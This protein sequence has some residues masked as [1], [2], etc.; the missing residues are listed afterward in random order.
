VLH[1]DHRNHHRVVAQPD[2]REIG[3]GTETLSRARQ[4]TTRSQ[5][6]RLFAR[7][8]VGIEARAHRVETP[9]DLGVTAQ[10]SRDDDREQHEHDGLDSDERGHRA[11]SGRVARLSAGSASSTW[12]ASHAQHAVAARKAR[13]TATLAPADPFSS[14]IDGGF[15]NNFNGF[16]NL[17]GNAL[18]DPSG[19]YDYWDIAEV[20]RQATAAPTHCLFR[21][22]DGV[23][24]FLTTPGT[25]PQSVAIYSDE[26]GEARTGFLPGTGFFFD[27]FGLINANNGCDLAGIS[28]LGTAGI[29]ATA[30]YPYE[31]VTAAPL[32]S[33]TVAKSVSS[34]FVKL[35]QC[36]PKGPSAFDHQVAVCVAHAQDITGHAITGERVCFVGV[37]LPTIAVG[38]LSLIMSPG[39]AIAL[40][41]VH[42]RRHVPRPIRSRVHPSRNIPSAVLH[43]DGSASTSP[44]FVELR[45]RL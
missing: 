19:L 10:Q 29:T 36:F 35:I 39:E 41:V 33:N 40:V 31:P 18:A 26:H 3:R 28:E 21:A 6:R 20:L 2:A 44:S 15:A 25:G 17:N 11:P 43:R 7:V 45:H 1:T 12:A 38:L 27:N 13:R 30:R 23:P 37:G 4:V 8:G 16:L 24:V 22:V 32:V 34:L 42:L 5:H 9:Q 14:G